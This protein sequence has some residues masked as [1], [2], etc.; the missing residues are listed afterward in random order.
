ML[1]LA[2]LSSLLLTAAVVFAQAPL[3]VTSPTFIESPP[4][5]QETIT[6][7]PSPT[8]VWIPGSWE[9]TPDQWNWVN[10]QW[11]TPPFHRAYW[12]PGYWQHVGGQYTWLPGHWAAGTQGAVVAEKV[13]VPAPLTEVQPAP[14][15]GLT[16]A[17]WRPG[18]WEWR[19]TWV[20]IPGTYI[21][22]NVAQAK[23]VQGDW[24]SSADGT[25]RWNPAHWAVK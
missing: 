10:G 9:R 12:M 13:A 24:E 20:W 23:W 6:V 18:H 21:T 15:A 5:Q 2:V 8:A 7:A 11:V 1:R 19:G 22:A 17:T 25:W 4:L 3:V 16:A 14:P